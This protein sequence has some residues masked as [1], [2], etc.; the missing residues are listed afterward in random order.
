MDMFTCYMITWICS[1]VSAYDSAQWRRK[2]EE[3]RTATSSRCIYIH[4]YIYIHTHTYV[5]VCVYV[6]V[7]VCAYVTLHIRVDTFV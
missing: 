5:C 6:S 3:I 1:H 2:T 4:I 7:C